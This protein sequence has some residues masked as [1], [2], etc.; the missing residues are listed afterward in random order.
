MQLARQRFILL[1]TPKRPA[2]PTRVS[3]GN[4]LARCLTEGVA[5]R[6][7]VT[8]L[9][10]R[11]H[12]GSEPRLKPRTKVNTVSV[13][14]ST[15]RHCVTTLTPSR[16]SSRSAGSSAPSYRASN[17]SECQRRSSNFSLLR[18]AVLD[19]SGG[20]TTDSTSAGSRPVAHPRRRGCTSAAS[21]HAL[22]GHGMCAKRMQSAGSAGPVPSGRRASSS[23]HCAVYCR[24]AAAA[25][26][27]SR[28]FRAALIA[29]TALAASA[30]E[31]QRSFRSA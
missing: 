4:R 10:S 28:S 22:D 13:D 20:T 5:A 23:L 18:A 16:I 1:S 21:N 11:T 29:A 6:L 7:F 19:I 30:S 15:V 25:A 3:Y 8:A 12:S 2:D 26:R 9:K 17:L 31:P 14:S 27:L 24:R